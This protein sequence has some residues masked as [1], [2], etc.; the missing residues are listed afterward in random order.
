MVGLSGGVDSAVA[1]LLLKQDGYEVTGAFMINFSNTKNT[2]EECNYL[3]DKKEAQKIAAILDIPLLI[4]NFEKQYRKHVIDPMFKSYARGLTPNPDSLCNKIIKFP[5]LWKEAR[6]RN[7]NYIATGHYIKKVEKNNQ[8]YLKIP[9]D[10]TKDQ[11]YFLYNLTQSDLKHTLFPISN[12]T[13][14]EVRAIAHK[15]NFPNYNKPSTNGICFIG[16]VDMKKFLKKKIKPKTGK[17]ID[18]KGNIIGEHD[19]IMYYTIGERIGERYGIKINKSYRNKTKKKLYVINKHA[20]S[21][22]LT[23]APENHPSSFRKKFKIIKIN[24]ITEKPYLPLNV[25]I[26]IRHLGKLHNA[27]IKLEKDK[28]ICVLKNP[29]PDI[30]PGQSCVIYKNRTNI[31]LGGGEIRF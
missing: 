29:L 10:K 4:L 3:V 18:P 14:Q 26:R 8:F 5:L 30:A 25:K 16:K 15:N 19:G 11:S 12:L 20:H 31:I 22:V 27:T 2:F 6:K 1:A 17:A 24:W 7:I 21:N 9:G 23:I 28:L 13:K